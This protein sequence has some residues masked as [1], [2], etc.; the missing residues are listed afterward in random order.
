MGRV[1]EEK[2]Y[3][4]HLA[5]AQALSLWSKLKIITAMYNSRMTS[6]VYSRDN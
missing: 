3:Y 4:S 5:F 2:F 6:H 1:F